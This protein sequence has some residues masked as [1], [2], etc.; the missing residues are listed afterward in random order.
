MFVHVSLWASR[1]LWLL[2]KVVQ[3]LLDEYMHALLFN[4]LERQA[5]TTDKLVD[6]VDMGPWTYHSM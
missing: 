4:T 5:I 3:G 2:R 1:A 6:T